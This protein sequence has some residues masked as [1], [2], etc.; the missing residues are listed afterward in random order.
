MIH[1]RN[2]TG[3]IIAKAGQ[4]S[5]AT[6]PATTPNRNDAKMLASSPMRSTLGCRRESRSTRPARPAL[7]TR[8][9]SRSHRRYCTPSRPRSVTTPVRWVVRTTA[10]EMRVIVAFCRPIAN[11]AIPLSQ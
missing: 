2:P 6:V 1:S 11:D 9:L 4:C 8:V 10:P 3:T 5:K 7:R